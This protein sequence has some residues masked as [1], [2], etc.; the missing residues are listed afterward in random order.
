MTPN[1]RTIPS[2][3]RRLD[4]SWVPPSR[5]QRVRPR[6]EAL[7]SRVALSANQ[8]QWSGDGDGTTWSEASNWV[9]DAVPPAGAAVVFPQLAADSNTTILIDSAEVSA[10]TVEESYTFDVVSSTSQGLTLESGSKI[11]VDADDVLSLA[12]DLPL[13]ASG[14]VTEMGNGTVQ[15]EEQGGGD[16]GSVAL[17]FYTVDAGTFDIKSTTQMAETLITVEPNAYLELKP[18]V[19]ATILALDGSAGA[20]VLMDGGGANLIIDATNAGND[21]AGTIEGTAGTITM[22]GSGSQTIGDIDPQAAGQFAVYV[23]EGSLF[24]S[25][26]PTCPT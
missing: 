14:Q 5:R 11:T 8:F 24:L 26:R 23:Q 1:S 10:I 18:G 22:D 17:A 20:T 6:L 13:T 9:G 19:Q 3:W 2:V 15:L 4:H 16:N 25:A 21:F 7:E 12:S